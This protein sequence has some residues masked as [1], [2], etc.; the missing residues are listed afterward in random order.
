MKAKSDLVP[1]CDIHGDPMYLDECPAS[2]LGLEGDRDVIVWRCACAGCRRFFYGTVGYRHSPPSPG[3]I[4]PTPRCKRD[5]AYLVVQRDLAG[6]ICPVAGC[7]T[8][9]AWQLPG[10]IVAETELSVKEPSFSVS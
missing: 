4:R 3:S 1:E 7:Q 8:A 2:A 5:G 6:Y 9:Q 10:E